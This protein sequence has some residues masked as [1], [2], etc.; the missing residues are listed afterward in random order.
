MSFNAPNPPNPTLTANA[1]QG[2]NQ[3]A[4]T[5]QNQA[6]SYNQSTPFGSANYVADSSSPSG[7]RLWPSLTAPQQQLLNQQQQNQGAAG[8]LATTNLSTAN[9]LAA[10]T[11]GMYSRAPQLNTSDIAKQLNHWQQQ[12][13][14]Q[15]FD[16]QNSN[17]EAQLRTQG[18]TPGSQAYDNAKNLLARNQGDVTN[19]YLTQNEG[20]AFDQAVQQYQ[21]PL[22]TEGALMGNATGAGAYAA[23]TAP[24]F[25]AT[26][27]AQIQPA[28]YAGLAEQNYQAQNQNYQSTLQ[29]LF[30]IPTALAGGWA[31]AGFPGASSA[32]SFLGL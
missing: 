22:Q 32:L 12:Y 23:P 7:Y 29:G 21:L 4:A 11:A 10:N 5:A 27:T 2:Y 13:Q 14:Q 8:N 30:G 18:L 26:P 24:Q 25:Q 19:Q 28:N 3:Q 17:L 16:Q 31:K 1:Q 20:Q 6:N 9:T 15:I